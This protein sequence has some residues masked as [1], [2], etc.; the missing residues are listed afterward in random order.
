MRKIRNINGT[1]E[2]SARCRCGT[3][4]EHWIKFNPTRQRWPAFC[5]INNCWRQAEVGA[6][7]QKADSADNNWY[8]IPLCREHNGM[9]NQVFEINDVVSLARANQK[10]TCGKS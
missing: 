9:R 4:K 10:E 2:S 1:D 6:H 3:W 7:V 8:I 5:P